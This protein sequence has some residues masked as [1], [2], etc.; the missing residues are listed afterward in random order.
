MT[1]GAHGQLP[2]TIAVR[3]IIADR[4]AE[5]QLTVSD[6]A[7]RSGLSRMVV[8]RVRDGKI[9][10]ARASTMKALAGALELDVNALAHLAYASAGSPG[11]WVLPRELD[12]FP[13]HMRRRAERM[14]LGLLELADAARE[15]AG[16]EDSAHTVPAQA[17]R[18]R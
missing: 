9:T 6:V 12:R 8:Y 18:S 11:A 3:E 2:V 14:L 4:M 7:R 1:L 5:L 17:M 10:A 13:A 15:P 16:A